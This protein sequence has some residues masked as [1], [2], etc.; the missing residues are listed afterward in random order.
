MAVSNLKSTAVLLGLQYPRLKYVNESK[1][2]Y[3]F[4]SKQLS[5]QTSQP[6]YIQ[7]LSALD[8]SLICMKDQYLREREYIYGAF[9]ITRL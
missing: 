9:D 3:L 6:F 1:N 4:L 2:Y 5:R 7:A 8:F